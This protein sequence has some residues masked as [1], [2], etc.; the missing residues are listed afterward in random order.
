MTLLAKSADQ[1]ANAETLVDHSKNVVKVARRLVQRLPTAV[2]SN[3]NLAADLEVAAALHDIGK[4]ASGFQQMVA[5]T[6]KHWN[7]WRHETLSASFASALALSEEAI[8]AILTHHR[9]V[10]G[11]QGGT[12]R[13]RWLDG[14]PEDWDKILNEWAVNETDAMA[15]WDELREFIERNDLVVKD[16]KAI[17]EIRLAPAWLDNKL[18]CRQKD[19]I[20][21]G[22]RK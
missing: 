7:Q 12:G 5:G 20:A 2:A 21:I 6:Q 1:A 14:Y 4:A 10:P 8:F 3:P 16:D 18:F 9:Q 15:V 11:R 22:R 19:A 17:G 13:L